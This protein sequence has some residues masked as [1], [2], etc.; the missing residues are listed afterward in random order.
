MQFLAVPGG[1]TE[2]LSMTPFWLESMPSFPAAKQM[3][4]SRLW[5]T[6]SSTA[7]A[8]TSYCRCE[9]ARLSPQELLCTRAPSVV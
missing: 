8:W 4:M 2:P 3:T 9:L 1:E 5:W 6:K 7:R